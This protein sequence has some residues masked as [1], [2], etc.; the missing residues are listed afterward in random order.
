MTENSSEHAKTLTEL[1]PALEETD[2]R[3]LGERYVGKVRDSYSRQGKRFLIATDRLSAFDRIITTVPLKGQVLTQL[4]KFWFDRF[5]GIVRHH[6]VAVPDPCVMVA[7][8]VSI[9]PVEVVVRGFLA[10]SAWRDYAAGRPVSGVTL[11]AGL[12]EF[13]QLPEPVITPSTKEPLGNHD[14]PI[15]EMDIVARGLATASVWDQ[16]RTTAL[17]LFSAATKD[18]AARGLLFVDTKYEF[19]LLDG[20]VVLADEIHTLDSSR[21]WVQSSYEGCRRA[22]RSPEMLDKEPIR[23]WLME[24]GFQGDGD[25][26]SITDEYRASLTAHYMSSY[27][28]ITGTPFCADRGDP[29]GR[30]EANLRRYLAG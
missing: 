24:Q 28:R 5:S 4:A 7:R 21:F 30:I 22:G 6:V 27:E 9:V 10:G 17:Q 18:L 25:L 29:L 26:P 13:D 20:Q 12:Q 2:F 11:P 3:W 16:I 8:E 15:S 23:R 1:S 19:G 14:I